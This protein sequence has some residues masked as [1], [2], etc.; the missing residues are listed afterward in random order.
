VGNGVKILPDESILV[1]GYF[2]Y[3][4]TFGTGEPN[5]ITVESI[6]L[7]DD[8]YIAKFNSD[9]TFSYVILPS[10]RSRDS[11]NAISLINTDS[12]VVAGHFSGSITFPDKDGNDI[13]LNPTGSDPMQCN[14]YLAKYGMDKAVS[15]AKMAVGGT[16]CN[17]VRMTTLSDGSTFIT[18]IF[19]YSPITFGLGEQNETT[20][21]APTGHDCSGVTIYLARY[22]ADGTLAWARGVGGCADV[23]SNDIAVLPDGSSIIVG[24]FRNNIVFGESESNQTEFSTENPREQFDAFIAKYSPDGSLAWARRIVGSSEDELSSIAVYPDGGF[25]VSGRFFAIPTFGPGEINETSVVTTGAADIL[26]ARYDAEGRIIWVKQINGVGH[27]GPTAISVMPDDSL[28]LSGSFQDDATFGPGEQNEITLPAS[29]E[30]R[31]YAHFIA[32]YESDGKLRW[33]I[34]NGGPAADIV[35]LS[36]QTIYATGNFRG[37]V[38]FGAGD[39][40]ETT[41]TSDAAP[42]AFVMRLGCPS[43]P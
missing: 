7:G 38:V 20:L 1:A 42:N 30:V 22:N 24:T 39:E 14:V 25:V 12:F 15:W 35:P 33:A 2:S 3:V 4:T 19:D 26:F 5:E 43:S 9:G 36:A 32:R 6:E 21:T 18:G 10:G 13:T 37:T 8:S 17:P 23:L 28:V 40:N 11:A 41:Y 34:P 27:D 31:T 16:N 29:D